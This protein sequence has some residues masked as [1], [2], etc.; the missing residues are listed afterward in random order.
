VVNNRHRYTIE[1]L[2]LAGRL[3]GHAPLR[4]D[5]KPAVAC[6]QFAA[7]RAGGL[8]RPEHASASIEPVW[9]GTA[10]APYISGFRVALDAE[11]DNPTCEFPISYWKSTAQDASAALVKSGALKPGDRFL[12]QV[13]A[14]QAV[15]DDSA[16]GAGDLEVE[17]VVSFPRAKEGRLTDR[18]AECIPVGPVDAED[19]PV[20]VPPQIVDETADLRASADATETGGVLIGH[21][22]RDR[23]LGDVFAE[24]TAQIPARYAPACLAHIT[25]TAETWTA[26]RAA[27][28]LRGQDEAILGWWHSHPVRDWSAQGDEASRAGLPAG[29]FFSDDDRALHRTAF[30][31]AHCVALVVSDVPVA[32]SKAWTVSWSLHG[33]RRGVVAPRGFHLSGVRRPAVQ[34]ASDQRKGDRETCPVAPEFP[35]RC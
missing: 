18:L 23:E 32:T 33:W 16:G 27:V 29:E 31:S 2:D 19:I 10:G 30:P 4:P 5:W 35:T 3:L 24:V 17:E 26:C 6:T 13:A 14:Y 28:E 7:F 22:Y 25:F 9:H 34:R 1:L 8:A 20:I 15:S 12:F 11:G 21:L